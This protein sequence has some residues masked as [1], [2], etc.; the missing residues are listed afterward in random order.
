M[1]RPKL[2]D[3]TYYSRH[4]KHCQSIGAAYQKEYEKKCSHTTAVTLLH[5]VVAE[6]LIKRF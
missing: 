2:S 3:D 5:A 4:K 1:A 6:K